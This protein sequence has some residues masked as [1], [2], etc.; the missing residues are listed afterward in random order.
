MNWIKSTYL[1]C[2]CVLGMFGKNF[3]KKSSRGSGSWS[4][5][6]HFD[7][8]PLITYFLFTGFL[9]FLLL[10][11]CYHKNILICIYHM[12]IPIYDIYIMYDKYM[13]DICMIY[14]YNVCVMCVMYV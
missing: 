13:Y 11:Y 5:I 7:L 4:F 9:F 6:D 14:I 3:V 10:N 8:L 12:D 1:T 2:I